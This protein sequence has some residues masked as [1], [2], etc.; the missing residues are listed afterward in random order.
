MPRPHV[1]LREETF[2]NRHPKT[3]YRLY[4]S[5]EGYT[6]FTQRPA[7][8]RG[9]HAED[10][11][12]WFGQGL[13]HQRPDRAALVGEVGKPR[14]PAPAI[15]RRNAHLKDHNDILTITY[16]NLYVPTQQEGE[17][18]RWVGDGDAKRMRGGDVEL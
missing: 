14:S 1:S 4:C 15:L 17:E 5:F 12:G 3:G 7:G 9:E 13:D 6:H 10:G 8:V 2:Q 11:G 16:D 18:T